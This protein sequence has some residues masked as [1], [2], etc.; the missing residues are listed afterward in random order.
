VN[1]AGFTM[2]IAEYCWIYYIHEEKRQ[3][4]ELTC[5]EAEM[6]QLT[7]KR[8]SKTPMCVSTCVSSHVGG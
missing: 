8:F 1:F 4:I 3:K 7:D 2:Y 5:A 6:Q